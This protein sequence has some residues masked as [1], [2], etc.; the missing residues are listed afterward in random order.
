MEKEILIFLTMWFNYSK[1]FIENLLKLILITLNTKW[2]KIMESYKGF[3]TF[4]EFFILYLNFKFTQFVTKVLKFLTD[5]FYIHD[6][7]PMAVVHKIVRNSQKQDLLTHR[8]RQQFFDDINKKLINRF[9]D[10]AKNRHLNY[11]KSKNH[12]PL[13]VPAMF[14]FWFVVIYNE[15]WFQ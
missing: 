3:A 2:Q 8:L 14:S 4:I 1:N 5:I 12:F 10:Y 13:D 11:S 15:G 7:Y 6:A 9:A